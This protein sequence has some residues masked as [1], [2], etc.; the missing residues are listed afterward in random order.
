MDMKTASPTKKWQASS[1]ANSLR[2]VIFDYGGV[3]TFL[4][5]EE[6]WQKM[7]TAIGAPLPVVLEAYWKHRYPY[8]IAQ[9]DSAAFW[10]LVGHDCGRRL[11][12]ARVRELVTLDNEQ[13]GKPNP[14][15]I[16]LTRQ[17]RTSGMRTALLSNIQPDMLSFVRVRHPWLDEF[18][19]RVFSCLVGEAKPEPGIFLHAAECLNL[20]PQECLFVDDREAN[21][22]G[23]RQAGMQTLHFES[24]QAISSLRQRLNE[25]EMTANSTGDHPFS[26]LR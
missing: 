16:A 11:T 4:P 25:E 17:L 21:I 13:W 1:Q 5:T 6:D 23:A 14:E 3:L 8:E 9:Y 7:A 24:A 12:D 22:D 20:R 19:V 18:E 2:A 26:Q 10:R 15:T